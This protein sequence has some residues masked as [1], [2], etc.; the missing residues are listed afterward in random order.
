M[1][2]CSKQPLDHKR[3]FLFTNDDDPLKGNDDE[4]KKVHIVAKVGLSFLSY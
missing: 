4:K 3:V 2:L 1:P